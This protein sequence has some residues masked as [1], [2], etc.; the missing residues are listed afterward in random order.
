MIRLT[1]FFFRLLTPPLA[2]Y[3]LLV[4]S[5]RL[6]WSEL[7]LHKMKRLVKAHES[8]SCAAKLQVS[9]LKEDSA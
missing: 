1:N 7:T 5:Q 9:E 3:F 4:E 6:F 8:D 2:A